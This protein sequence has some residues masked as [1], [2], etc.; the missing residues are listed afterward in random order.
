MEVSV[1]ETGGMRHASSRYG[2]GRK[3]VE[4]ELV[5]KES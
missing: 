2:D 1:G 4:R 5:I 3:W